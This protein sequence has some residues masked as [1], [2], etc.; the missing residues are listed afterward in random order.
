MLQRRPARRRTRI[1]VGIGAAV[2]L[3]MGLTGVWAVANAAGTAYFVSPTGLDTNAGTSAA[4]PFKS[5]QKA[6]DLAAPGVDDHPGPRRL[7]PV[8]RHED[9]RHRR[10]PDHDQGPRDGEGRERPLQDGAVR[11]QRRQRGR[12]STTATTRSTGSRSTASR[13]STTPST[14][15][16][17]TQVR[18][19]KDSVQSRAV[20]SKLVYVGADRRPP[21]TSPARASP[22]CS[23]TAP[24]ASAAVP[25]PRS[26]LA[27]RQLGDPVVRD[28]RA[29]RRQRP[30]T[31][32]T[33]ARA[34]TSARAPN[35]P[36]SRYYAND[37]SNG[38]VIR[39]SVVHTFGAE[40]F[41]VK[42]NANDN[43]IE[44]SDCGFNDEP[45]SFKGSNIELRGD[46]NLI[47]RT[48]VHDSRQLERQVGLRLRAVQPGRQLDR[49]ELVRR[50]RGTRAAR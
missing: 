3:L 20:N 10:E 14:R 38:V 50:R 41:E 17:S 45:L 28:V 11:H 29:G 4:A 5:I 31:A 22:T 49:A 46:H 40:C 36:T 13:G 37:T 33:T 15:P 44:D 43:R 8:D 19:F 23:S 24:A 2:A 32:T 27:R 6:L 16:P 48:A 1:L 21:T 12:A 25:Q 35:R 30:S 47:R 26:C 34:S 39:D 42:E 9:R 18:A 7:P